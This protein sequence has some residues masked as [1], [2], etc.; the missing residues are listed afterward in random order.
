M[1]II[2]CGGRR[3]TDDTMIGDALRKLKAK[4]P[5]A[6][7]VHGGASG[8][9]HLAG[10]AAFSQG[11][12]VERH[13]AEW[14]RYGKAAGW[15]RNQLMLDLG[16]DMVLAFKDGF[17]ASLKRGGTEHMVRIAVDAGIPTWVQSHEF[18]TKRVVPT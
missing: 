10:R 4:H 18:K 16:A 2:I 15:K 3:W 8:A 17:D 14:D 6:T 9:D 12:A 1:R 5:D 13:P 7:I 11:F